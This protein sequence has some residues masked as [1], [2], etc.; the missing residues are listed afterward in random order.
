[1]AR[2]FAL[3]FSLLRYAAF[4]AGVVGFGSSSSSSASPP[5][6]DDVEEDQEDELEDFPLPGSFFFVLTPALVRRGL[7]RATETTGAAGPTDLPPPSTA[8]AAAAAPPV[9]LVSAAL[10]PAAAAAPA[11]V[12]ACFCLAARPD[13][14]EL[15][16]EDCADDSGLLLME[17][18]EFEPAL[19]EEEEECL[20]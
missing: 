7:E 9:V 16:L 15:V 18:V 19:E 10:A 12:V 3:I 20:N 11:A 1:M 6:V 4:A 5:F 2:S 17:V 8:A 14:R 13:A